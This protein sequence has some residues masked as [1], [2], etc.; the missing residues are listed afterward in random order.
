MNS[1]KIIKELKQESKMWLGPDY[2]AQ[3]LEI[4]YAYVS[5]IINDLIKQP[6]K[7]ILNFFEYVVPIL[8]SVRERVMVDK[9]PRTGF[10]PFTKTQ[11]KLFEDEIKRLKGEGKW[12]DNKADRTGFKKP[13][14]KE[15]REIKKQLKE[16]EDRERHGQNFPE[17][18]I[19]R[20]EFDNEI[21]RVNIETKEF[22][23]AVDNICKPIEKE[24]K[25]FDKAM[26]IHK[27][28]QRWGN[29]RPFKCKKC[30]GKKVRSSKGLVCSNCDIK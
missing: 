11:E 2:T 23:K 30:K 14:E 18:S 20:K 28:N 24:K 13:T 8:S 5:P 19:F 21:K 10:I 29:I 12:Y 4:Y 15:K 17:F 16:I 7:V 26:K 1:I 22:K 25:E 27:D 9:A 3:E 6:S